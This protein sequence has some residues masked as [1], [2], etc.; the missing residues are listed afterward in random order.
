[1]SVTYDQLDMTSA[2]GTHVLKFL[3][4]E[5]V[6]LDQL[7]TFPGNANVGDV[8]KIL[9]SM[10]ANGV[11][12]SLIVRKHG[13]RLT[14]LAGNHSKLAMVE[15]GK[16]VCDHEE[17]AVCAG[18]WDATARC[19]V[20]ECDDQTA[21]RINLADNRVAEF[22]HRDDQSLADLLLS[23]EDLTGS[24]YNADDLR[25]YLPS[26]PPELEEMAEKFG[27]PDEAEPIWPLL[28]FRVSPAVRDE[29][30]QL[31]VDAEDVSDPVS[32]FLQ[33]MSKAR[34]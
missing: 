20:Y 29:F 7:E 25:L 19:E 33:L 21:I 4:Y 23:L 13:D 27:E 5:T 34:G 32:R 11:F 22:G 18:G 9:E 31:T 6:P 15:H 16:G 30:L 1:M 10:R 12:R 2:E 28:S 3:G 26:A 14:V 24:G 8:P 17:C